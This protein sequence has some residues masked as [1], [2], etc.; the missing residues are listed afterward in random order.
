V[1][2]AISGVV[3]W[4]YHGTEDAASPVPADPTASSMEATAA[5]PRV[6][7]L[8]FVNRSDDPEQEYFADGVS[9]DI[10]TDLSSLSGLVVIARNAS[11]RYKDTDM[12]PEDV[13]KEL[14][15]DY[16]LV[17]SIR[18]GSGRLRIT[19]ELVNASDGTQAWAERYDRKLDDLF[20]LQDDVTRNIVRAMAVQLTP[21]EEHQIEQAP[22]SKFEAYDLFLQG[23]KLYA[24]RSAEANKA[25]QEAYRKAIELDPG[26]GRAYGALA[27]ALVMDYRRGWNDGS[28]HETLD[29]ALEM[30][31]DGVRLN[32]YLP[33]AYWS[34]GFT[35]LFRKEYEAAAKAVERA[36]TLAPN[37]AD[38]YGLLAFINN[39]IG[40]AQEAIREIDRATAL[41]PHHT[42][43]YP[44]NRGWAFYTLGQYDKAVESLS[45]A[46]ER[47][48]SLT[49]VRLF[50][51]ASYEALGRHDDAEWEIER[52]LVNN[53]A[54]SIEQFKS[55]TAIADPK[56]LEKFLG[57]LRAAGLPESS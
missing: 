53:P 29:R 7:V 24:V 32:P 16:L 19:A 23:Q 57:H 52:V 10:I 55:T 37:Y 1:I 47:N 46:L 15:A 56:Q 26:Y 14:K 31:K 36:V 27:V 38:G 21:R 17:G 6:A 30:A 22:T 54:E 35:H 28:T 4:Q 13:A 49:H 25:A 40:N 33:Q 39:H 8:P 12:A 48:E 9:E 11:F 50:L 41:N 44:W 34:L 42:F 18:K 5:L 3:L 51:A 2:A 20:A 43:D 45:E